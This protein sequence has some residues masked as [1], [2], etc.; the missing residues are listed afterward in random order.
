M[1]DPTRGKTLFLRMCVMCHTYNKDER[2]KIGPNLF[3]VVGRT[4]GTTSGFNYT[5]PMKKKGVVWD[6]KNLNEYLEFPRQFIPGT[7]MVFNGIKKA[8]DRQDI[9]AFLLTL[10]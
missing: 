1:G 2:H 4:C 3:G 7:K 10:K 8:E 5:E 6:E 9:I